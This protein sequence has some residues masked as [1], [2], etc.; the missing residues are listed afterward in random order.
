MRRVERPFGC[1]RV[2]PSP[3]W[4]P[5]GP[6]SGEGRPGGGPPG[7][8]DGRLGRDCLST[9]RSPSGVGWGG[10]RLATWPAS[11]HFALSH[12]ARPRPAPFERRWPRIY[13][14]GPLSR[15]A[16]PTIRAD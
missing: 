10:R 4:A 14:L 2:E 5:D 15:S 9:S 3:V 13:H 7:D 11:A 12:E 8:R 16:A 1:W 6:T